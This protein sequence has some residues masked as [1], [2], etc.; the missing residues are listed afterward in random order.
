MTRGLLRLLWHGLSTPSKCH[1]SSHLHLMTIFPLQHNQDDGQMFNLRQPPNLSLFIIP[2]TA[3]FARVVFFY[4]RRHKCISQWHVLRQLRQSLLVAVWDQMLTTPLT[5]S[6]C[7]RYLLLP[8]F[9][10][11]SL[12]WFKFLHLSK[13][14]GWSLRPSP[15][16]LPLKSCY[17]NL[18]TR[19]CTTSACTPSMFVTSSNAMIIRST[20]VALLTRTK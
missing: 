1:K 2:F 15:S 18:G 17:S 4:L 6:K 13:Y 12:Q 5:F 16:G 7:I 11:P 20:H 9:R 10:L 8:F 3:V 14:V 19:T